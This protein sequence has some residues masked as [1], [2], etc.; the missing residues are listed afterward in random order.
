M[1]V[2]LIRS[3]E[4]DSVRFWEIFQLLNKYPGVV[5]F[6]TIEQPVFIED[7]DIKKRTEN[8]DNFHIQF[9]LSK[10]FIERNIQFD[11]ESV[12]WDTLFFK[13][14]QYRFKND[15]G[16]DEVVILLT[17]YSNDK[18]WFSASDPDG[19]RNLFI[20]TKYW[21]YFAGSDLRYPVVYLIITG[22]LKLLMFEDYHELTA[23][24]HEKPIGCMMDFCKNKKEI[25]FKLRTGDICFDCLKI[26]DKK[27]VDH[28]IVQQAFHI[29]DEIRTQMLFKGR[30]VINK[31]PP[32]LK[33]EGRTKKFI[34]PDFGNLEIAL[35]PLEKTV[36]LFF[37]NHPDG[38]KLNTLFEYKEELFY[39][40]SSLSNSDNNDIMKK[41]I[42]DLIDPLSNSTSE[43]ISRIKKKFYE[44]LG[45]EI[46]KIFC[47][48]G[49]NAE[50]KRIPYLKL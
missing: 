32:L 1:N 45:E 27:G 43:K 24:W 48:T 37:M 12:S 10:N 35:T 16:K 30:F 38:I 21:D 5:R 36:Y 26:I 33:I 14:K 4:F 9:S 50:P 29:L 11:V 3:E 17:D 13:C 46:G 44:A 7:E 34:F 8:E 49:E 41:R 25:S 20:Q 23:N 39:I 18:N 28:A 2:H 22:I 15:L 31:K 42:D 47:I 6:K 19:S 40:Y